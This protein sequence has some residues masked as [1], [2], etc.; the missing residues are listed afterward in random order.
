[1]QADP[2]ASSGRRV[3]SPTDV[4]FPNAHDQHHWSY[5]RAQSEQ[6]AEELDRTIAGRTDRSQVHSSWCKCGAI[7]RYVWTPKAI[8]A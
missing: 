6:D 4:P 5:N 8:A 2:L 7:K 1:M 3:I